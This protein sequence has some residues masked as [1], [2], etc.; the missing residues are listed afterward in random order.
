MGGVTVAMRVA[1][2]VFRLRSVRTTPSMMMAEIPGMSPRAMAPS[3]HHQIRVSPLGDD[4]GV[5]PVGAGVV[6]AGEGPGL[7]G[8]KACEARQLADRFQDPQGHDAGAGRR[9]AREDDLVEL[10]GLPGSPD[11]LERGTEVA[12]LDQ[13]EDHVGPGDE[14]SHAVVVQ[15]G[16]PTVDVAADIR[17]EPEEMLGG[18]RLG[19]MASVATDPDEPTGRAARVPIHPAARN[20]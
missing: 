16:G 20:I 18:D 17:A 10:A 13:L 7:L 8:G 14:A 19:T 5:E 2:G 15:R 9:V 11:D 6:S 12:G 3:H 4:A 1:I